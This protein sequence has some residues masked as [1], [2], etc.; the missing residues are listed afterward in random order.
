MKM[1]PFT[2]CSPLYRSKLC[3]DHFKSFDPSV[4][5]VKARAETWVLA[6]GGYGAT[7]PDKLGRALVSPDKYSITIK[8][9]TIK[10][11]F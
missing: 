10:L 5:E 1:F 9:F 3:I 4:L 8:L 11:Y 6:L 7:M 2:A